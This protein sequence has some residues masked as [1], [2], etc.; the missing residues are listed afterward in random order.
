MDMSQGNGDG[1]GN[2]CKRQRVKEKMRIPKVLS[3]T[4]AM[5]VRQE[6]EGVAVS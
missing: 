4:N 2:G 5:R 6:L 1:R 3:L